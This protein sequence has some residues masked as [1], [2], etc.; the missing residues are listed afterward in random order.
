MSKKK[1][2]KRPVTVSLLAVAMFVFSSVSATNY[3]S[4][5]GKPYNGPDRSFFATDLEWFEFMSTMN[6][7]K[8]GDS[9][10]DMAVQGDGDTDTYI[11]L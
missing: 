5:C 3:I 8:C 2:L 11:V 6:E 1:P 4:T 9:D 10:V 7:I